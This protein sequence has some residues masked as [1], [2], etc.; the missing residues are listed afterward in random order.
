MKNRIL[1]L[2]CCAALVLTMIP[3]A[4]A[5]DTISLDFDS[6]SAGDNFDG[7]DDFTKSDLPEGGTISRTV[8]KD[9]DKQYLDMTCQNTDSS[10]GTIRNRIRTKSTFSGTFTVEFDLNQISDTKLDVYLRSGGNVRITVQANGT[11]ML[12]VLDA[13][14]VAGVVQTTSGKVK[15]TNGKWYTLKAE[16]TPDQ[17]ELTV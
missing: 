9:G 5:A 14:K 11:V 10:T 3:A 13:A 6:M 7:N 2:L 12:Q 17:I 15:L 8:K 16:V 4:L 1:S